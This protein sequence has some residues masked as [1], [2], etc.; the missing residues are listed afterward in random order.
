MIMNS[1]DKDI[2][3][4][5]KI[6]VRTFRQNYDWSCGPTALRTVLYYQY[7]INLTELEIALVSGAN[8]N[9]M[10]DANFEIGLK[11]LGLKSKESDTGTLNKLKSFLIKHKLPIVHLVMPDGCGHYMVFVGYDKD[12]VFLSDPISGKIVKYGISF[13]LGVWKEEEGETQTRWFI[14]IIGA[15]KNKISSTLNKLKRIKNKLDKTI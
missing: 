5:F 7:G 1:D 14:V 12:N 8:T 3:S 13:F 9:G 10:N 15:K 4:E 2:Y 11:N 6:G